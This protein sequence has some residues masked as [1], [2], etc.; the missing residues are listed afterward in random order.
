MCFGDRV[1]SMRA[2][3]LTMHVSIR[4]ILHNEIYI[5]PLIIINNIIQSIIWY[6]T[7]KA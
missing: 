5:P 7:K 4:A 1:E 2:D 3:T 6:N